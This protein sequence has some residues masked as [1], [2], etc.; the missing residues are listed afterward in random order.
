VLDG[1]AVLASA[2]SVVWSIMVAMY[3]SLYDNDDPLE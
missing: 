3:A 2:C 1:Q